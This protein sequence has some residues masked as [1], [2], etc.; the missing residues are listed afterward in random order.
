MNVTFDL[1]VLSGAIPQKL[2]LIP[3]LLSLKLEVLKPCPNGICLETKHDQTS[4]SSVQTCWC[5]P[6]RRPNEQNVLQGVIKSF[7]TF[8]FIEQD[9]TR[10]PNGKIFG[11]QTTFDLSLFDRQIF[12]VW[13]AHVSKN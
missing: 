3:H 10:C 11:H 1:I 12:P 8:N 13:T 5:C 6:D 2:W 4:L 9:E 7:S